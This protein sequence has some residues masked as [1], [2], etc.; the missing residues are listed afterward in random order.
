MTSIGEAGQGRGMTDPRELFQ[1]DRGAVARAFDRASASYDSAAALQERVR[2]EL[3][4]RLDE[5]HVSPRSVLDLG[6]RHWSHHARAQAP[7]SELA[8]RRR[9]HR[10]RHAGARPRAI[11][12]VAAF[13]RVRAD[14]YSLPFRDRS[15]DLCSAA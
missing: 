2:S 4:G 6:A 10:A 3:L 8:C 9:R 11:A 13:R 15:F 5:L 12:L 14:A 1:L 7:L